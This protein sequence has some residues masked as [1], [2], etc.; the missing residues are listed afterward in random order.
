[1]EALRWVITGRVQGVWY[2]DFTRREARA[3]GLR[4]WVRNLPDGSVEARVL[5]QRG[6]IARLKRRLHEGPPR[7]RVE[8]IAEEILEP[9][10]VESDAGAGFE[11]RY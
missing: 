5:G 4:G 3:L 1:M 11:V 9:A 2:R 10:A 7:A 6:A 8:A